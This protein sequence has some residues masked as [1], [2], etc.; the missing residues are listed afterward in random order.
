MPP[1]KRKHADSSSGSSSKSDVELDLAKVDAL[2]RK[3]LTGASS[4]IITLA[5]LNL[6]YAWG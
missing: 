6:P 3:I 4:K 5:D 1:K 2:T